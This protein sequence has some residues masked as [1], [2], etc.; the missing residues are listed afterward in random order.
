[1]WRFSKTVIFFLAILCA[2]SALAQQPAY[3]RVTGY[4]SVTHPIATWS[5]DG[6]TTNF[7]DNYTVIFPFGLNLM[8]SER[9]GFSM[10]ISPSVKADRNGSKVSSVLFHPGT[11]FRFN[12]GFGMAARLAF[13][14]SGRYGFTTVANR[15]LA[16][17]DTHSYWVAVPFPVRFG[18][19]QPASIGAGLQLGISF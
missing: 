1:M 16:K 18:N 13:D 9:F 8:K 17:K 2:S 3:P 5:T 4:F 11:V 15:T 12:R 14:T 10:E 7:S 19:D 6:W